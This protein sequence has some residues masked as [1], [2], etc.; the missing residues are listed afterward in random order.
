MIDSSASTNTN[1]TQMRNN[2]SSFSITRSFKILEDPKLTYNFATLKLNSTCSLIAIGSQNGKS[3]F[4]M[5]IEQNKV[6]IQL[7]RGRLSADIKSISFSFDNKFLILASERLSVH[8]FH[9]DPHL[10]IQKSVDIKQRP[11]LQI[12][13]SNITIP[14]LNFLRTQTKNESIFEIELISEK[15]Y[16][17][18]ISFTKDNKIGQDGLPDSFDVYCEIK[19]VINNINQQSMN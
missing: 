18:R 14:H 4:I 13:S 7:I 9:L 16:Y 5:D 19:I 15:G 6:L 2:T 8:I 17:Y 1:S 12:S 3:I 11:K 10:Q